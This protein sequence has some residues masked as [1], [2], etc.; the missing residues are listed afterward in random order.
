MK[1][2][3]CGDE[4]M[5]FGHIFV[6]KGGVVVKKVFGCCQR[7]IPYETVQLVSEEVV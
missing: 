7:H 4:L 1:C 3:Q 2:S 6:K 5:V